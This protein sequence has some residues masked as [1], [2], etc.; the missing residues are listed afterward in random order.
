MAKRTLLKELV[1]DI[2]DRGPYDGM[3]LLLRF[4]DGRRDYQDLHPELIKRLPGLKAYGLSDGVAVAVGRIFR[5]PEE[6]QRVLSTLAAP[7]LFPDR[8]WVEFA[9]QPEPGGQYDKAGFL[10]EKI[11]EDRLRAYKFYGGPNAVAAECWPALLLWSPDGGWMIQ[12]EGAA[13]LHHM[14]AAVT[15]YRALRGAM[16]MMAA[17]DVVDAVPGSI[18][19]RGVP[20]QAVLRLMEPWRE[21][22]DAGVPLAFKRSVT[23]GSAID[24]LADNSFAALGMV[25]LG[26]LWHRSREEMLRNIRSHLMLREIVEN[27]VRLSLSDTVVSSAVAL[28]ENTGG[29][30]ARLG[31]LAS[32]PFPL[33]VFEFASG[34]LDLGV[35]GLRCVLMAEAADEDERGTIQGFLH[36]FPAGDLVD[37]H[38][39]S[40]PRLSYLLHLQN[41]RPT[42]ELV[43]CDGFD[44]ALVEDNLPGFLLAMF[45]LMVQPKFIT[46]R[47]RPIN[48][49]ANKARAKV[50][51]APLRAVREVVLNVDVSVGDGESG[52]GGGAGRGPGVALHQ[53]RA[54]WRVRLGKLEFV[55]P[56]WR[57]NAALGVARKRYIVVRDEDVLEAMAGRLDAA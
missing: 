51:L 12:H 34:D 37:G 15:A 25:R 23:Q 38:L 26:R 43:Q 10:V 31:D 29:D 6:A 9:F 22:D 56:F 4:P 1:D 21:V 3:T 40:R 27:A 54:F 47:D 28:M 57:G 41:G 52:G 8:F 53:V 42:F 46:Q 18:R 55:R 17:S 16:I 33:S 7:T 45:A 36:G 2:P 44:A 11:G 35:P 50:R 5:L 13:D 19:E 24:F 49:S 39:G 48:H 20:P 14:Q 30:L 32:A